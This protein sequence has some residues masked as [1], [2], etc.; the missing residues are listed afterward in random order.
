MHRTVTFLMSR[1]VQRCSGFEAIYNTAVLLNV[2]ATTAFPEEAALEKGDL[3]AA[4]CKLTRTLHN[5]WTPLTVLVT[6]V[7][8]M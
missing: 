6:Q 7:S 4:L 1:P 3:L 8:E 5:T 2:T